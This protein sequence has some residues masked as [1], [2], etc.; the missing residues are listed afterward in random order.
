MYTIE[1]FTI[2]FSSLCLF[3]ILPFF[4]FS[5]IILH[6]YNITYKFNQCLDDYLTYTLVLLQPGQHATSL[7]FYSLKEYIIG[8]CDFIYIVQSNELQSFWW[9]EKAVYRVANCICYIVIFMLSIIEIFDNFMLLFFLLF[10]IFI[11]SKDI[12]VYLSIFFSHSL[13]TEHNKCI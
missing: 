10:V 6:T 8:L 11:L 9:R 5:C 2:S 7:D 3:G 4:F 1:W 13:F 12:F